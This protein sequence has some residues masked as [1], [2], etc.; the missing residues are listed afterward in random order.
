[1]SEGRILLGEALRRSGLP[2]EFAVSTE[3]S[4]IDGVMP[5]GKYFYERDGATCETDLWAVQEWQNDTVDASY[6]ISHKLSIECEHRSGKKY[7][8]FFPQSKDVVDKSENAIFRGLI[9]AAGIE[10]IDLKPLEE[11][12]FIDVPI[13]G[14]GIELFEKEGGQWDSN[15]SAISNA[16]R[17]AMMPIGHMLPESL[18]DSIAYSRHKKRKFFFFTPIIITTAKICVLKKNIDWSELSAF[19][20]MD[21]C[22]EE[23][24]GVFTVFSTPTYI[25]NFWQN[26]M[27]EAFKSIDPDTYS[28]LLIA[29]NDHT[30]DIMQDEIMHGIVYNKPTRVLILE[31]DALKTILSE[32][33]GS[34][35]DEIHSCFPNPLRAK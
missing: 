25:K 24:K 23:K 18:F 27:R 8:C 28:D 10:D 16:L 5:C 29:F 35:K 11:Q 26:S 7:W 20:E 13:V 32:Y 14:D 9:Q 33:L 17:Q 15:I 34:V 6:E 3:L 2:L 22:F 21:Q 4:K 30:D 1:M 19:R 12:F 31:F